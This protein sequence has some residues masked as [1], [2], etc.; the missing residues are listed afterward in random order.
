MSAPA[1][2]L[3]EIPSRPGLRTPQELI[4]ALLLTVEIAVF[5]GLGKNFAT[6][7]NAFQVVRLSVEIGLLS[8]ALT[9]VIVSGGIDLSVGSLMGLST[10][11]F[12]IMVQKAELPVGLAVLCTVVIGACAGALNG[13]LIGALRLPPLIVT[14]GTFSLFRGLGEG[15]GE[16]F[17]KDTDKLSELPAAFLKLGNEDLFGAIPLQLPIW[18]I[19]IAGFW[20]LLHRTT[21]GRALYAIGLAPDGARHAGIPVARRLGLVYVLSGAT[22]SVAAILHVAR[23]GVAKADIG[24]GFELI[25]ITAVVLGGTSIFGGRGTILGTVLGF[26]AIAILRRGLRL[27]D[28]PSELAGILTGAALLTTITIERLTARSVVRVRSDEQEMVVKNSQ[29]AF[30]CA[31][32]LL[33][34]IIVAGS[35][36]LLMRGRG[37]WKAPRPHKASASPWP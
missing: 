12:G 22:A 37:R 4:L 8:L 3:P 33:G 7:P 30:I 29:V 16:W 36:W 27:A 10:V 15:L 31:F 6:L 20:V 18:L 26:L 34:A 24:T 14:L 1:S 13:L 28:L 5:C 25:A 35:N 9:P 19:A 2:S 32:I 23:L 21:V 17:N 11:L